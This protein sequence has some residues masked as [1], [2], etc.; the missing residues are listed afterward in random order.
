M[1]QTNTL[2]IGASISG[3]ACA[4]SLQKKKIDYILIEKENSIASP[5]RNH[6]ERLHLHTV[7]SLS[8]LPYKKMDPSIPAYASRLQVI[9]YLENYQKEFNIVPVLNTRA[10]SVK[11]EDHHWITET[12]SGVFKSKHLIMATGAYGKPKTMHVEGM[13]TFTGNIVHSSQYKTGKDFSGQKVL[14]VGFGNSACEIAIDLYEQGAFPSMSVRSPVNVIPRDI[15]GISVLKIS[16]LMRYLPPRIADKL[17]APLIKL[18]VGDITKSGLKK[19][20]YGPLEEIAEEGTVPVIDIGTMKH[21]RAGNIIIRDGIEYIKDD[22]V[23]FKNNKNERFDAIIAAIGYERNFSDIPGLDADRFEDLKVSTDRQKYFGKDGLYF[24]GYWIS[25][26]GQ[27]REIGLDAKK[28][29]KKIAKDIA[30]KSE[31]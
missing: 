18:L 14:V 6:Y 15:L 25:P 23:Y 31:G 19:K 9:G 12:T 30:K 13:E 28:I 26:A 29:A 17:S 10:I 3:L 4:V 11:R 22:V 7:K 2:I 20:A 21:I 16:L 5:W 8:H 1:T 27:I 24:C